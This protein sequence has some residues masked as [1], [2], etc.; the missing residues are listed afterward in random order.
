MFAQKFIDNFKKDKRRVRR[1]SQGLR[2]IDL[3]NEQVK[4]VLQETDQKLI[5]MVRG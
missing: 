5:L 4:K 3:V 2:G 1:I